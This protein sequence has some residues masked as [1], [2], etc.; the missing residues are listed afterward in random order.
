MDDEEAEECLK[1]MDDQY[2]IAEILEAEIIPYSLEYYL[3][4]A[5]NED[6]NLDELMKEDEESDE[7]EDCKFKQGAS[8]KCKKKCC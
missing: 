6:A 1:K 7:D 3:G 5:Q 8:K 4:V 2:N